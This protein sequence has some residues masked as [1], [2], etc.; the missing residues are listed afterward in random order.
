MSVDLKV[1]FRDLPA[2]PAVESAVREKVDKLA[3]FYDRIMSCHVVVSVSHPHHQKGKLYHVRIDLMVPG[4][5][6]VVNREGGKS[7][8]HH[9]VYVSV[10]DAFDA[11][12]RQLQDYSRRRRG[13]VKTHQPEGPGRDMDE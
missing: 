12:K 4:G 9:D 13:E 5:E 11:A 3:Q 6:L 8:A 2:S 7:E 1:T 10:R